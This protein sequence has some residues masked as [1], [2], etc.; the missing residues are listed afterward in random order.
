M[1][2]GRAWRRNVI[3]PGDCWRLCLDPLLCL[4]RHDRARL[5]HRGPHSRIFEH[6]DAPGIITKLMVP[7]SRPRDDLRK[8]MNSQAAREYRSAARLRSLGLATPDMLGYGYSIAPGARYE[9][10]LLMRRMEDHSTGLQI[11]RAT[12]RED[13]RRKLLARVAAEL[14]KI[15]GRGFSHRDCHFANVVVDEGDR[16][17]WIDSDIRCP[18]R[19]AGLRRGMA[20]ALWMLETT[21]RHCLR[22]GEWSCFLHCFESRLANE[23]RARDLLVR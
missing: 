17:L 23:P 6:P 10:M 19:P 11:L 22:A 14:A 13:A 9:S 3:A 8:Y 21:A 7:R 1:A 2:Q 18:R 12:D 16:L 4:P 15:Y 20:K 5:R